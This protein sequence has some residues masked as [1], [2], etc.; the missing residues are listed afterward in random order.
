MGFGPARVPDLQR[1]AA[2]VVIP[3]VPSALQMLRDREH[4]QPEIVFQRLLLRLRQYAPLARG[5][6]A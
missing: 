6:K 1:F 4:S 3:T 5:E 2:A